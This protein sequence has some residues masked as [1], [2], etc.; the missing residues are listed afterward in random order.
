MPS[1]GLFG[2]IGTKAVGALALPK[3]LA[4]LG[5]EPLT[6]CFKVFGLYFATKT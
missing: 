1:V 4:G 6:E 3:E 2:S 5:I